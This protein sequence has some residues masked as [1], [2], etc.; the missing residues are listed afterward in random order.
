MRRVSAPLFALFVAAAPLAADLRVGVAGDSPVFLAAGNEDGGGRM[1][2]FN[3]DIARALCE[4]MQ[5]T[6]D[7]IRRERE[8]V[9]SGLLAGEYDAA[10]ASLPVTEENQ[11]SL[12]FTRRYYKDGVKFVRRAGDKTR[13]SYK[14]LA[15]HSVGVRRGGVADAF[16]SGEFDGVDI[17]RYDSPAAAYAA[18]EKGEV[19]FVIG[20]QVAQAAFAVANDDFELSGPTYNKSKYFNDVAVAV[21]PGDETLRDKLND[22]IQALRDDGIYRD[23]NKRYFPF[24]IYGR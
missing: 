6:C 9:V 2:G 13:I 22:A 23:I 3:A 15:G 12:L 21:R 18:L 4:A 14:G 20:A 19:G 24:S 7:L 1:T 10:V 5:V 17:R 11:E 8:D 16:L